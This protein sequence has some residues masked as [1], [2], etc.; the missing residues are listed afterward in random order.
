MSSFFKG[1]NKPV[2]YESRIT[3]TGCARNINGRAAVVSDNMGIYFIAGMQEWQQGWL[4]Q[5]V[6][7]TGD[8]DIIDKNRDDNNT[9]KII[10][11][12]AIILLHAGKKYDQ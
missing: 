6:R 12:A 10:K 7:M 11:K 5:T 4:N 1:K 2:V 3:V 8:L 9:G